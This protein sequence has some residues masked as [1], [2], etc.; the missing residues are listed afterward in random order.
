MTW[1]PDRYARIGGSDI[2]AIFGRSKYRTARDVWERVMRA[3][4]GEPPAQDK[5]TASMGRGRW[6]ES[7]I[8]DRWED[9][10]HSCLPADYDERVTDGWKTAQYDA[11]YDA[12]ACEAKTV[13]RWA[14]L[15]LPD[16]DCDVDPEDPCI[17]LDWYYQALWQIRMMP[18]LDRVD[19]C[20]L[21][22][23]LDAYRVARVHRSPLVE[24]VAA[25]VEAWW[26]RYVE[27][28]RMPPA[29]GPEDAR[30]RLPAEKAD[31]P[32]TPE[33]AEALAAYVVAGAE[34]RLA[35][36]KKDD[37]KAVLL[38]AMDGR[39]RGLVGAGARVRWQAGRTS[40]VWDEAAMR[41]VG[42]DPAAYKKTVQG[43][44]FL[45]VRGVKE[46]K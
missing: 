5:D 45:D 26:I 4:R 34:M 23:D 22:P 24:D 36:R 37:A 15:D 12:Y 21:G 1:T 13:G 43:R 14:G 30:A 44:A 16:D 31:D 39:S 28:D 10:F 18:H 46:G 8:V 19:V 29:E 42:I 11:V 2:A 35:E 41:A 25:A 32:A 40:T 38:A 17:P 6:L 3:R 7:V 9:G 27:G 20:I 33:V